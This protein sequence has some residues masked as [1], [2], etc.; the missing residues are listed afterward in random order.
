VSKAFIVVVARRDEPGSPRLGITASRRVGNSVARNRVKRRV[1]EWFRK[2]RGSLDGPLDVLVIAR[3]PATEL[4]FHE[5]TD[6]LSG[7]VSCAVR[8]P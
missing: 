2:V 1:R 3:Q 5:L 6:M 4:A 7:L 8:E